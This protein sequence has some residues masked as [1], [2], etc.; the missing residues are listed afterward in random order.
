MT[1]HNSEP[2]T[3]T[4]TQ[5]DRDGGAERRE[6]PIAL[7]ILSMT[8]DGAAVLPQDVARA[9]FEAHRRPKDTDEAWRRYLNPVKQQMVH[10]A[11]QGRVDLVRKRGEVA[12]PNDFK[13]VVRI[14]RPA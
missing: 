14:R 9:F 3:D 11:R 13:G 2:D 4:D 6:D 8:A 12:D 10:M 1:D 7:T 5:T